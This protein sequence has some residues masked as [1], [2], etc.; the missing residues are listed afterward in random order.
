MLINI[1]RNWYDYSFAKL[2]TSRA[3]YNEDI[4]YTSKQEIDHSST[5]NKTSQ[6]ANQWTYKQ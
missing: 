5:Q 3:F 6:L 2:K 4:K 1:I